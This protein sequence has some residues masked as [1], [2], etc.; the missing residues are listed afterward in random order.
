MRVHSPLLAVLVSFGLIA[1]G[2]G[3]GGDDDDSDAGVNH[4]AFPGDAFNFADAD[5]F[6]P[7]AM[8][9]SGCTPG[10]TE[11]NNCEDDDGDG[12]IDGDDINCSSVLD[13][14]EETF[15]TGI[16]GDN[17][18]DINQD[19]FFDG[20]S[21]AGNDGCRYHTCCLFPPGECPAEFKPNMFDPDTDCDVSTECVNNCGG[22]VPPG[23]GR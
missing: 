16:P 10:G 7:D 12:F 1:C 4:D 2:G 9:N 11:C 6:A 22:I 23:C 8:P 3:G 14:D 21:G 17:K 19:C 5:P 18:D 13:D 20:D 15:A